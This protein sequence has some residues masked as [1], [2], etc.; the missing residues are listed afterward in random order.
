LEIGENAILKNFNK[1]LPGTEKTGT[2]LHSTTFKVYITL[3]A[4][5]TISCIMQ[6]HYLSWLHISS[7]LTFS[8]FLGIVAMGQNSVI[9]TG[10]IDLSVAYAMNF[11][12][13]F[14]SQLGSKVGAGP[15]ILTILACGILI[16]FINGFCVAVL[17]FPPM[18]TTLATNSILR[19][20]CYVLTGGTA[21]GV[22]PAFIRF[23][24]TGNIFGIRTTIIV[25]IILGIFFILLLHK[26]TFGRS[27]FLVGNNEKATMLS[28]INTRNTFI[29]TY[30]LSSLFAVTAGMVLA[31]YLGISYLGMGDKYQMD[32]VAAC[33]IGG[34]LITGGKGNYLGTVGGAIIIYMISSILTILNL[35]EAG[36]NIVNGAVIITVLLIYGRSGDLRQ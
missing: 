19:S 26:T 24:G 3:L 8:A 25:W 29:G 18:I 16:G 27:I 34:T 31:G 12:G 14:I 4:V 17:K 6:P 10:G 9:L 22:V 13:L 1:K 11:G 7:M 36:L 15:A 20:I 2:L 28:G 33:V 35:P 30:I 21:R 23:I 32:S 5:Y